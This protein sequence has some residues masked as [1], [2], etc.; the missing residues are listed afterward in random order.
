MRA[1]VPVGTPV[2]MLLG[3]PVRTLILVGIPMSAPLGTPVWTPVPVRI[4]VPAGT[5]MPVLLGAPM[6]I[7]VPVGTPVRTAVVVRIPVRTQVH[8]GAAGKDGPPMRGGE[9]GPRCALPYREL[10]HP[11]VPGG[12]VRRGALTCPRLRLFVHLKM[13]AEIGGTAAD[14]RCWRPAPVS[15]SGEGWDEGGEPWGPPPLP[16]PAPSAAARAAPWDVG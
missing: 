10:V 5:P 6:R 7:P 9:R 12:P 16:P 15:A 4:P 2:T 1:P 11:P 3:A 13:A 8:A 14:P